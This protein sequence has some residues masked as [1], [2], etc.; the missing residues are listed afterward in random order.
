MSS[1]LTQ[2]LKNGQ[3]ALPSLENIAKVSPLVTREMA[4]NGGS[5]T[6]QGTNTYIIGTGTDRLLLDTGS[7]SYEYIPFLKEAMKQTGCESLK[8]IIITHWHHDHLGG[9]PSIQ[10]EFGME[11]PI[12]IYKFM[13]ENMEETFGK[14]EG[15]K[16]PFEIWPKEKFLPL[17]TEQKLVCE[18]ATLRVVHTP[19][20]ASDHVVV[21]LEEENAMFSGDNVLGT[22]TG[23]FRD[24]SAY[25]KSLKLMLD[26]NPGR[27][28]PGHGPV[29]EDGRK[30]INEYIDHRMA[31]L[32]QVQ[33]ILGSHPLKPWRKDKIAA[34]I[35][36]S[37]P[38]ELRLPAIYNTERV[39][40]AL[41]NQGTV[42]MKTDDASG[43]ILWSLVK[44]RL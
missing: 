22:G 30:L 1:I 6:L 4:Q 18:G 43:E 13:P 23:V 38:E 40:L 32:K 10:A 36:P 27:L 19:G 35:Y 12:P 42:E 2:H 28:Y 20:H 29:V 7:G 5:Y 15:S 9:V 39:L 44:E 26:L 31:R 34:N 3:R 16:N 25:I 37:L 24:L 21:I 8:G 17:V 11:N 14:G 41:L 33:D